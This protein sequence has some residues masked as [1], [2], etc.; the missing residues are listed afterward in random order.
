ML[1]LLNIQQCPIHQ[2]LLGP[3]EPLVGLQK[4]GQ[5][6]PP[7]EVRQPTS[8]GRWQ[9]VRRPQCGGDLQAGETMYDFRH[10]PLKQITINI[11][12]FK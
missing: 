3:L 10:H 5:Q 11:H 1:K 8:E 4:W 2:W 12:S 6:G 7:A 9:T